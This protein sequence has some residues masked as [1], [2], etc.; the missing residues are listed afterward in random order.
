G[1]AGGNLPFRNNHEL[2]V[3]QNSLPAPLHESQAEGRFLRVGPPSAPS[4]QNEWNQRE[5]GVRQ[6][7]IENA[8]AAVQTPR[9]QQQA[10]SGAS[11]RQAPPGGAGLNPSL[12]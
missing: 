7:V 6:Q 10:A 5:A 4:D 3:Y 8:V 9:D 2:L 1:V 12:A 11:S